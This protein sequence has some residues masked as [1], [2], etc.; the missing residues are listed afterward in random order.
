MLSQ[1][2]TQQELWW[3]S[4]MSDEFPAGRQ[5]SRVLPYLDAVLA[6]AA[7]VA[8]R[9]ALDPTLGERSPFIIFLL[10]VISAAWFC[11][12]GPAV[13]TI[14]L[15]TVIGQFFFVPPRY[16]L[17][18]LHP[19]QL[20][21]LTLFLAVS[22]AILVLSRRYEILL[23]VRRRAGSP[24]L[25]GALEF[26]SGRTVSRFLLYADAVLAVVAAVALRVALDP[27][28]GE[29][30]PFIIFLLAVI[31]VAWFC[32][33]GPTILTIALSTII[34]QFFFVPPRYSLSFVHPHQVADLFLFL[35]VSAAILVLSGRYE[36]LLRTQKRTES[37]LRESEARALGYFELTS[38]GMAR[39]DLTSGR[40]LKVNDVFCQITGYTRRELLT[41]GIEQIT[42]SDDIAEHVRL[43]QEQMNKGGGE[44]QI[45]KRF[46]RKDGSS[47][48]VQASTNVMQV[49]I[50]HFEGL[51]AAV[52]ITGRKQAE[53]A[54]RRAEHLAAAGRM[55]AILAHEIN[56]PLQGVANTLYL[57]QSRHNL[58]PDD[59]RLVKM[60]SRELT[61]VA[62]IVRQSL[63]FYR[64]D[65][66]PKQI[67]MHELI[68]NLLEL[69]RPRIEKAGITIERRYRTSDAIT[70][71]PGEIQQ[72]LSNLIINA[73]DAAKGTI[74]IV[75]SRTVHWKS[76]T[77]G[78]RVLIVDNGPGITA[79]NRR[80]V[81]EPFFTTKGEN[82]TGLGLWVSRGIVQR[83]AGTI[84]IRTSTRPG[85]SGSIVSVF[86]PLVPP[87]R[88][89]RGQSISGQAMFLPPMFSSAMSAQETGKKE[90]VH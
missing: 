15:S 6:V 59:E 82:G 48:W 77:P 4:G 36:L 63:D 40:F 26:P 1:P 25:R 42:D 61:R 74:R 35:F 30:A 51:V 37:E 44:F 49:G 53:E 34:G 65:A 9:M 88:L 8:L 18:L 84:R 22:A 89:A 12:T 50:G 60:A 39:C 31:S 19:R 52:D 29:R 27:T 68:D 10:A 58:T 62:H 2:T 83:H 69:Y 38:V 85:A 73:I 41:L 54:L 5:S 80:R 3:G 56:N 76:A 72:V 64:P 11:G 66:R 23:Q 20:A 90:T 55:A 28:L 57:L 13:V 21:D 7:A 81:F 33:P 70:V 32:G 67:Q 16:T 47:V 24:R 86:L 45:E 78:I 17:D 14:A 75:V 79:E 87:S 46:L 71:M 43:L